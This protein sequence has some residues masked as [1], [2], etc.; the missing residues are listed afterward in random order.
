MPRVERR[1]TMSFTAARVPATSSWKRA[2]YRTSDSRRAP[3]S[4]AGTPLPLT[5]PTTSPMRPSG[6]R[7]TS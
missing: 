1:A 6:K 5:S 2:S 4:A 7:I 3:K